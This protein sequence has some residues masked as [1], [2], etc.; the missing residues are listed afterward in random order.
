MLYRN[1]G[2][3]ERLFPLPSSQKRRRGLVEG[4][5][6]LSVSAAVLV[7]VRLQLMGSK[8]PEFAPADN[9]SADC[10]SR[11]TRTLTFLYLPAFNFWLLLQPSVLSF[12]WSMEAIP[13]VQRLADPRN[14]AT[15]AL[16]GAVAYAAWSVLLARR[17]REEDDQWPSSSQLDAL[18]DLLPDD[19]A[20][21]N[22]NGSCCK[23]T[24]ASGDCGASSSSS[25]RS[26]ASAANWSRCR[27]GTDLTVI[28]LSMLVVPFVP[29]TNLFFYVGFVVAERVLYIPSIG[30]CLLVALGFHLTDDWLGKRRRH[31]RRLRFL[32]RFACFALL[33]L[34]A[35]RTVRRNADWLSEETLYRSG[36]KVNPPKGNEIAIVI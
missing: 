17:A 10:P 28:A 15:L 8:A 30:Y 34:F 36:I 4:L 16:Y 14:L 27:A 35:A 29:A 33:A 23:F 9:P 5:A 2:L 19:Q 18:F 13:L 7:A 6:T 11:L 26:D 25:V 24:C 22:E 20:N 21:G 32:W 31:A 3:T 12:D 1:N